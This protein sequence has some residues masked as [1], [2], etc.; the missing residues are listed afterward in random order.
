MQGL[1]KKN[2]YSHFVYDLYFLKTTYV[3]SLIDVNGASDLIHLRSDP[4]L[5]I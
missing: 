4:D 1:K 3:Y 2:F 5:K